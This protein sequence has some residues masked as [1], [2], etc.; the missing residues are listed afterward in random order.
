MFIVICII[1]VICVICV[2]F[3]RKKIEPYWDITPYK[4]HWNI[5]KCLDMDCIK[6]RSYICNRWCDS[7]AELG[8]SENCRLRCTDYADQQ[9]DYIKFNNYT[10]GK[11][12][13]KFSQ[14][15]LHEKVDNMSY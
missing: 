5:F 2:V 11:T 9:A 14:Y 10:W 4:Y 12:L 6:K 3:K 8:G 13:P 1:C 7:W 15:A